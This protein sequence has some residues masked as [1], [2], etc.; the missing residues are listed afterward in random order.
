MGMKRCLSICLAM[1]ML[2]FLV[3]TPVATA[4]TGSDLK[5]QIK[6]DMKNRQ[7]SLNDLQNKKAQLNDNQDK[8]S[9][10]TDKIQDLES[11]IEK[12]NDEINAK[13]NKV[14][15]TQ[16]KVQ[17]LKEKINS[18]QHQ[19]EQRKGYIAQR[20]RATYM[21]GGFSKYIQLL[22]DSEKFSEFVS[23]VYFISQI[24]KQDQAILD[25]QMNDKK[26]LEKNQDTLK[27][28]LKNLDSDLQN[29]KQLKA[30]LDNKKAAEQALMKQLN[31]KTNQI[32]TVI[33]TKQQQAAYYEQLAETHKA[34]LRE[35]E[36]KLLQNTNIPKE[37]QQFVDP[38]QELQKATNIPAAIT[39]AQI[40]LE[41]GGHLSTLATEGKNLFGIKGEGPAGT[42]YLPTHEVVGG[43]TIT[44]NAGFKK[45]DTYY[46]SMVDHAKIL[47]HSRYQ[48]YLKDAQSLNE[49]AYGIQDGGYSTDPTYANKL[50]RII[51]DYGLAKYDMGSF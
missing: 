43:K 34:E 21:N 1:M 15:D 5:D 23:R 47:Q 37:V 26:E 13:Q 6:Q 48:Y 27:T 8:Q 46:Q 10:V 50:L 16:Q 12:Y 35:W 51:Q 17:T 4:N 18:L 44:I 22:L 24:R 40:I 9:T 30:S 36:R 33:R 32:Q 49:Y 7:N 38:A 2:I 29:I 42:I 20:A 14:N 39:I 25:N 11:Q 3:E 28:N 45:Y 19:I 41:S 31:E